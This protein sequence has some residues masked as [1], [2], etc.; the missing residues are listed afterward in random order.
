MKIYFKKTYYNFI[1]YVCVQV[2][3]LPSEI[4]D[5]AED[6]DDNAGDESMLP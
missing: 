1:L 2:D 3:I 5:D 6:D 4:V